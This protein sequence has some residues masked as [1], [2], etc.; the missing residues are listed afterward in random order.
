VKTAALKREKRVDRFGNSRSGAHLAHSA[1]ERASEKVQREEYEAEVLT[2]RESKNGSSKFSSNQDKHTECVQL[3]LALRNRNRDQATDRDRR[4]AEGFFPASGGPSSSDRG[5]FPA[6]YH[7]SG[8]IVRSTL[9][10]RVARC[11]LL[12]PAF[13]DCR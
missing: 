9:A 4:N 13:N 2:L 10:A 5:E 11:L 3:R 8:D 1:R 6:R 7:A 12:F